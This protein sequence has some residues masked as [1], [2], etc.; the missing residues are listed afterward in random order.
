MLKIGV[1]LPGATAQLGEFLADARALDTAGAHALWLDE[2]A[3]DPWMLAAALATVTSRAR[4]GLSITPR[5]DVGV[6]VPRLRTLDELS[7]GRAELCGAPASV[8]AARQLVGAVDRCRFFGTADEE[9]WAACA[10]MADGLVLSG[11]E[12]EEDGARIE[13]ARTRVAP[14]RPGSP[15]ECWVQIK[16]PESHAAWRRTLSAYEAA[17][18]DGLLVPLDPR[19]VDLL[20]RAGEEDDRSDLT[21]AQG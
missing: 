12:P 6:L 16:L 19:L 17:G 20:R 10:G 2:G 14:A 3:Q 9:G 4:L 18:A 21:L 11:R 15:L 5:V 13:R 8:G 7:R 1:L